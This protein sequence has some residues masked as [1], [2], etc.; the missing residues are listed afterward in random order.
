M[1]WDLTPIAGFSWLSLGNKLRVA[2][3]QFHGNYARDAS[4]H[5]PQSVSNYKLRKLTNYLWI[6]LT[7]E[8]CVCESITAHTL[9]LQYS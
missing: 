7:T 5:E 8:H 2:D 1:Y 9:H 4:S 6:F 3:Q